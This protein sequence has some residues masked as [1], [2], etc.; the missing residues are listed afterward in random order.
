ME[1]PPKDLIRLH[2]RRNAVC[3]SRG[4]M[5]LATETDGF[6]QGENEQGLFIYETRMLSK[7]RYRINGRSLFPVMHS[8]INQH[9]WLGYYVMA[10]PGS[11]APRIPAQHIIEARIYRSID[12]H[13][14]EELQLTNYT[15]EPVSFALTLEL[16]A[17][18]AD[19]EETQKQRQQQGTLNKRWRSPDPQ[20]G[21][22]LFDYRS[23]H[24]YEHQEV[25]GTSHLHRGFV[26]RISEADAPPTYKRNYISFSVELAPH[27]VWRANM[28]L[29]P[30]LDDVVQWHHNGES[31][32]QFRYGQPHELTSLFLQESTA[33]STPESDTLSSV[34][35]NALERSQKDLSALRLY[36]LDHGKRSWTVAA[37][38]P[39]YLALFGRDTLTAGWQSALLG[40]ELMTGT[41]E[42]LAQWQGAQV[43]NW[44]D[45]EPGR[46]LHEAH[47]GP[48]S[49]L[50]FN[51][52]ARYYG[53]M[54]TSAFYPFVV[55]ELWRWTGDKDL[56]EQLLAPALKGMKWLDTHGDLDGDGFYEYKT[57]STQGRKNQGWKDSNDAIVYTDGS[58]VEA[59]IATCELQGFVYNAKL[60]LSELCWWFNRRDKAKQLYQEAQGLKK[61]FNEKFWLKQEGYV[62]MGLDPEKKPIR[63]VGSDPGHC[64]AALLLAEERVPA[65]TN[66]MF[67]DDLFTGW[68]FRTLSSKHPAYN[69]YSYQRGSVW[70]V[71]H[72]TLAMGFMRYGLHEE[73]HKI[74]RAQFEAAALFDHYRLPEAIS[75]HQ[76]STKQPFPATYP[77]ANHPQ[78]WS[79]SATVTMVQALLGIYPYA[80]LNLLLV[81]PHLPEWLP[82]LTLHQLRVGQAQVSIRFY[83]RKDGSSSYQ[84]KEKQGNLHVVQQPSPWSLVTSYPEQMQNTLSSLLPG[85]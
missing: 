55:S 7:Y 65:V 58:Q 52:Q 12:T 85:K 73:M 78:A 17:D 81:D 28:H 15:Q 33:F 70:P 66:R 71:E 2:P 50:N 61:R 49:I 77:P 31:G 69:P 53:S 30:V 10:G 23:E 24:V 43:N 62:A 63:S 44:R 18:F 25:Q 67:K 14:K 54:T 5:M 72:G 51:P 76:R 48:L 57:H 41:L 40:P 35:V 22:L 36:D 4:R 79:A 42:E 56:T 6:V 59:P 16:E 37:G 64:L 38:I 47:T 11:N 26:F 34:V 32:P 84:V 68:G 21:E 27:G 13:F 60:R 74:C 75:G 80:P 83:R 1:Y 20:T 29:Q 82:E 9:S 46:M 45:E 3:L 8:N 39:L 19:P